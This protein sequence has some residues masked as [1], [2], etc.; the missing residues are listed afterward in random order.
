MELVQY[1]DLPT[2][3]EP[4]SVELPLVDVDRNFEKIGEVGNLMNEII[5]F[6][7]NRTFLREWIEVCTV[8]LGSLRFLAVIRPNR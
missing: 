2:S 4:R 8:Y 7:D 5:H 6:H 3:T 1:H